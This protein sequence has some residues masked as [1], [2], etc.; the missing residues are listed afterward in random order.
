M[1]KLTAEQAVINLRIHNKTL[2]DKIENQGYFITDEDLPGIIHWNKN[3]LLLIRC[4]CGRFLAPAGCVKHFA[5]IVD[6]E[7]GDYVR[8]ISFPA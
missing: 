2:A 3:I 8:D 4:G 5:D 1:N 7:G 6:R